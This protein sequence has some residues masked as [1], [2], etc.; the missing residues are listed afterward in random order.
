MNMESHAEPYRPLRI[1]VALAS[2]VIILA[3]LQAAQSLF[4]PFLL[5][6]FIAVV[7]APSVNWLRRRRLPMW[8]ALM[9]AIVGLLTVSL[10]LGVLIGTSVNDFLRAIP[11]YERLLAEKVTALE[12]WLSGYGVEGSSAVVMEYLDPKVIIG[13]ASQIF[14]GLGNAFSNAFLILF[15][16]I[17]ILLETPSFSAKL[18]AVFR[19]SKSVSAKVDSILESVN[20][21]MMIK[22]ATSF[23]T[24][25]LVAVWLFALGV[26]YAAL[27]GVLAFL[28]NFVPNIGSIIAA[29][30]AVLLTVLQ[31]GGSSAVAVAVGYLVINTVIGNVLEPRYMGKGLGMSTLIVFL[32]LIFWGWILGPVGMLLS[33]PLTMTLKIAL[34]N[35]PETQWVS[36]LLGPAGSMEEKT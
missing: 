32:S 27:W 36:T 18:H 21:Y 19:G 17:L 8:A 6:I 14:T 4:I 10:L 7:C 11:S 30:P 16:V 2:V 33:I 26:D 5:S 24:G 12:V 23:A 25:L 34:S 15:I 1:L 29:I 28:F 3:G 22:T 31:L 13:L 20:R 35:I 9:V